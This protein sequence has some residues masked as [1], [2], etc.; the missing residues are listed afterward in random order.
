MRRGDPALPAQRRLLRRSGAALLALLTLGVVATALSR[1]ALYAERFGGTTLRLYVMVFELWLAVVVV[2]VAVVWLR[3]RASGCRGRCSRPR[4]GC[5]WG[6]RSS[7]PD[8]AVARYDVERFERTGEVDTAY[9]ASLSADAVPALLDL[10]AP[11]RSTGSLGGVTPRRP[12]VRGQRV[13]AAGGRAAGGL[14][15][16]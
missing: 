2:L 7:G 5:C 10:P 1:M 14:S 16:C 12:L 11:E 4:P 6:S 8:A 13:A 15:G 3:G 9:L